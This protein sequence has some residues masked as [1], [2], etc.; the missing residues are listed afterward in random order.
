M[1]L[2]PRML[3]LTPRM[4]IPMVSTSWMMT[5]TSGT[6]NFNAPKDVLD[7]PDDD[8]NAPKNY[9]WKG[10]VAVLPTSRTMI[11]KRRQKGSCGPDQ[12]RL[13]WTDPYR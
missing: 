12:M 6:I 3:I 5:T 9:L 8:R 1:V 13:D 10:D 7:T 2:P 11:L 4:M